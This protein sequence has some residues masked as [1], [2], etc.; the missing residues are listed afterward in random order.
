MISKKTPYTPEYA[1]YDESR[2]KI[3]NDHLLHMIAKDQIQGASYC[4]ARHGKVFANTAVGRFSYREKSTKE[5]EPDDLHPIASITKLF[6]AIAIMKLFEDGKLILGQ[7][8]GDFIDEFKKPP[9][10]QV[11]IAGLLTHTSGMHPDA[12][13]FE[14]PYPN[15]YMSYVTEGF[16]NQDPNWIANA[17]RYG[18][19]MKPGV[20]WAYNSFGYLVLGEIISRVSGVFADEYIYENIIKPC[21]MK[22]TFFEKQILT[23]KDLLER[24]CIQDA[25][26][27]KQIAALLRDEVSDKD[28]VDLFWDTVPSTAGGIISK[29][30]DLVKLGNMMIHG[31]CYNGNRVLSRIVID[32]MTSN[33]LGN[34]VKDYCWGAGGVTRS[35]GL[36]CDLRCNDDNL[37]SNHVFF[38]EGAGSCCL[39]MDPVEDFVAAWFVPFTHGAW[40]AE[41]LRHVSNIIWSGIK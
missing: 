13:C 38:H 7:P 12:G 24:V 19:R 20:E 1:G 2:L 11:T 15:S 41:G 33:Q 8:V 23:K 28:P 17:L 16:R 27:E 39:M 40:Y 32:K 3:L 6:T 21:E 10:D 30:S 25:D 22:E 14:T 18:M 26:L 31:G 29:A 37:Y 34:S 5:L 35:Y 4:L 36:G 9:F